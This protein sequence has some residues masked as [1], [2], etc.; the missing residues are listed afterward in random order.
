MK[1]NNNALKILKTVLIAVP[2]LILLAM[3][4]WILITLPLRDALPG[5][6]IFI[7]VLLL[8]FLCPVIATILIKFS[9]KLSNEKKEKKLA[10][11]A[12]GE[13]I[14]IALILF[15]FWDPRPDCC[16]TDNQWA[17]VVNNK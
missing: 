1:K 13:V 16:S 11:L 10:Q 17:D 15:F 5:E 4:V 2:N 6:L 3:A 12:V 8:V 14:I 7:L 9:N